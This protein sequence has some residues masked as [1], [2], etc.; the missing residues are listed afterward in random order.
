MQLVRTKTDVIALILIAVA[1]TLPSISPLSSGSKVN[2]KD[3]FFYYAGMH[4]A[5]RKAVLEY[6]TFPTRSFW[7]S[8]G[9]PTLG[10]PEDPSLNPLTVI[11]IIFGSIMGLK[12]ITFLTLLIGGLSSYLLARHILGY[13][14]WGSLFCGL[15]FG[16]S[17]FLPIRIYDGNPNE[18]YVAF[19]P[20]CMLL[21]GMACRGRKITILMLVLVFYTMLSD[22]KLTAL[23]AF[24]YI[25]ILCLLDVIPALNIFGTE[26]L[27]KINIKPLKVFLVALTI[28]FCIGMPRILPPLEIIETLGGF[29]SQ[30]LWYKPH[31]YN[32]SGVITLQELWKNLI[33]Y[34]G[35]LNILTIGLLPVL[36][37]LGAFFIFPR[38]AFP[39]IVIIFLFAWLTLAY[40]APVD[41]R[42]LL[43]HLPVLK[44]MSKHKYYVFPIVF[45]LIIVAGQFFWWLAKIRPKWLA[46]V[47]AAGLIFLSVWFLYPRFDAMQKKTY[48]Y[49]IPPEFLVS[50]SEFYNIQGKDLS[51]FRVAPLNSVLYTNIVRNVGTIDTVMNFGEKAIPKYF[52]DASGTLTPNPQYRGEAHFSDPAN[53][54]S[55]V[56]RPNSIVAQVNLQKPDMLII[57]QNYH[58]DWHADRGTISEKDGLI[59]LPLNDTGRYQITLRYFPRSFFIGISISIL[60]LI[61]LIFVCWS[62][63]TGRLT[64]WSIHSPVHI[65]WMPRF[66][67][68]VM[69]QKNS[70][71]TTTKKMPFQCVSMFHKISI[72]PQK[73]KLILYIILTIVT[74]AVFWQVT[75]FNFINFDDSYYTTANKHVQSGFT[76][77]SLRWAFSTTLGEFWF[78]LTWLSLMLDHQLYGLNAGGY[79]ITNLLLH[80]LS[81]L[82]LF[83]LFHRMTGEIWKSAFVAFL[84]AVHPLHVETVVW[85]AKRKDVLSAFFWMLTLCF[86]VYYTEKPMIKRYLLVLFSFVCALMSK[87]MAVTLPVIMILLDYWPIKRFE[88]KQENIVLWQLKEKFP[89]FVLS[90]VISIITLCARHNPTAKAIPFPLGDRLANAPVSF[91]TYLEKMFWPHDLAVFY[92]FPEHLPVWQVLGSSILVLLITI[93]V[94]IAAKRLPYLFIGWMWYAVTLLPVLG[95]V[96]AS[97]RA[98]SDNY[99]YLPLIGISIMSAWGISFL[100]PN[101]KMRKK[102]LW[103]AGMAIIVI[104][105]VLSRQQ[106]SLWRNNMALWNHTLQVTENNYLAHNNRGFTYAMLG[107]YKRALEDFNKAVRLKPDY[108]EAL[109]NRAQ[110]Y[111]ELGQY[112]QALKDCNKVIRLMPHNENAFNIRGNI[113]ATLGQYQLAIKDYNRAISLNPDYANA[114]YNRG[115]LYAHKLGNNKLALKDFNEAARLEPDIVEANV[116]KEKA[117]AKPSQQKNAIKDFNKGIHLK[118]DDAKAFY[119]RGNAYHNAKQYQMAINAYSKGIHLKPDDAKAYYNRGNSYYKMGQYQRAIDDYYESIRLKKDNAEAYYNLGNAYVKLNQYQYAIEHYN[120]AIN[121]DPDYVKAYHNRGVVYNKIDRHRPAIQ[122]YN[123]A[124]RRNPNYTQAYTNRALLFFKTGDKTSGCRDAKKACDL[125]NCATLEKAMKE[126]LCR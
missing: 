122:D 70:E 78:P 120:K 6:H 7:I 124:I 95:I 55:A 32:P 13:T 8:G 80:I 76:L 126:R 43:W 53:T 10:N 14:R 108:P 100:F 121:L 45:S 86:Y 9:F 28:T 102:I 25:G 112:A 65:R 64:K 19:L 23:M 20:L 12:I 5:V 61:T 75:Q 98:M 82:M 52:V 4:E 11:T 107:Q 30:W 104:L 57:N 35:V 91:M 79:H 41:L 94:L 115:L 77:K 74:L 97:K 15:V 40:N 110:A 92:P 39:W 50:E 89:F 46:H 54:V 2:L 33:G 24:L 84:F 37:A 101:K 38:K 87:P 66:I 113:Y 18:I 49:D 73:Q 63:K 17:L 60:T 83:W 85:I 22:G 1:I 125:G 117:F 44:E 27:K 36:L 119:N 62:Y 99:T 69:G 103:P 88:S 3:D 67:L 96:E 90:A 48:T 71:L 72:R 106:C 109:V 34:Q 16:L 26:N 42:K 93:A 116:V 105:S 68:W 21:I 47:L 114:Y 29:G 81:T 56:F 111:L 58:K 51:R 31:F 118:P 123:E 59:A